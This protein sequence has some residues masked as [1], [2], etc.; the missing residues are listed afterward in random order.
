MKG[1]FVKKI[2]LRACIKLTT[3]DPQGTQAINL[4]LGWLHKTTPSVLLMTRRS[5]LGAQEWEVEKHRARLSSEKQG[6]ATEREIPLLSCCLHFSICRGSKETTS[7][8]SKHLLDSLNHRLLV[9]L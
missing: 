5:F 8:Q 1:D 9:L 7:E 2:I 3:G 6:G 4:R